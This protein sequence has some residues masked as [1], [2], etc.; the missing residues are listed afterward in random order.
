MFKVRI[1]L[2]FIVIFSLPAHAKVFSNQYVSFE[3]PPNW[4]CKLEKPGAE[5]IC[6]SH[7]EK[8]SKEAII[9]LTAKEVGPTDSLSNYMQHL[10]SP[11]AL[12]GGK[13]K[14]TPSKVLNVKQRLIDGHPWV[15]GMHLGSEIPSYY[16][17]YLV[18][19]KNRLAIAVTFSAH[20]SHYTK[21]AQDFLK[22]LESLRVTAPKDLFSTTQIE[23]KGPSE[24]IGQ[25]NAD[26]FSL[27]GAPVPPEPS[28]RNP[29]WRY[30][31]GLLLLAGAA[32]MYMRRKK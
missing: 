26:P 2:L 13:G 19:V 9:V 29:Y 7:L 5:W 31:L 11:R 12:R 8:Q 16:T 18:T 10:K 32:Y 6:V 17:R 27:S 4:N 20:K 21:Y 24:V 1:G 30:G 23:M 22:S 3:L 14:T 25:A 15:D 28:A